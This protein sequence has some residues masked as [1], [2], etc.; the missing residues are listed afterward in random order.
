MSTKHKTVLCHGT[1]DLLHLG[2]I[3]HF[4]KASKLGKLVVSVTTDKHVKKGPNRPAFNHDQRAEA[5]KSIKFVDEVIITDEPSAC[6]AIERVKPD[7]Y[8]KGDDYKDRK[9]GKLEKEKEEV[10]KHGGELVFISGEE[11]FSSSSIV[12]KDIMNKDFLESLKSLDISCD[13]ILE[14]IDEV[15]RQ[16]ISLAGETITDVYCYGEALGKSSKYPTLVFREDD[17]IDYVGGIQAV[18]RQLSG[19]VRG[20]DVYTNGASDE[21][22]S[23]NNV[24]IFPYEGKELI[25]KRYIEEKNNV[26]LFETYDFVNEESEPNVE[27]KND[28][29]V[30]DYGHGV[31]VPGDCSS[32]CC[33]L[34][35]GNKGRNSV[36]RYTSS[37]ICMN[38]EEL[39]NEIKEEI[40]D[41]DLAKRG[42]E[43]LEET[44][45]GRVLVITLGSQGCLVIHR[46]NI[47][48][49]IPCIYRGSVDTIGSGDTFFGVF[50]VF[51][52][53]GLNSREAAVVA[54]L[55]AYE[56]ANTKGHMGPI[57][58]DNLKRSIQ[59]IF[60]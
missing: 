5:I 35:A 53:N 10:E 36:S 16:R 6:G 13:R 11:V 57:D 14:V 43:F 2:H 45:G 17:C 33:Q 56:Q 12:N 39:C 23:Y 28:Y 38:K 9:G 4:E 58:S 25:K 8:V 41:E 31:M 26:R 21:S 34:N 44:L 20:V 52:D 40:K 30:I 42:G 37:I 48:Y 24:N 19:L 59:T 50:S 3:Q 32:I 60:K 49:E 7:F 22:Y 29:Y 46:N 55:L 51:Y 18:A 27:T 47:F 1:F 54:N 15:K